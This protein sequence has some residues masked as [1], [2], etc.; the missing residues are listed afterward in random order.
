MTGERR[1]MQ[2]SER[3]MATSGL[4]SEIGA[5]GVPMK[6]KCWRGLTAAL[7]A[8]AI[9]CFL[10]RAGAEIGISPRSVW[11]E[12]S[13]APAFVVARGEPLYVPKDGGPLLSCIYA[14]LSAI[15]YLPATLG[16]DPAS[17]IRIGTAISIVFF[18][19]PAA[20]ALLLRRWSWP[21]AA[22]YLSLGVGSAS[23]SY[24]IFPIHA[25]APAL[26]F[27][28]LGAICLAGREGMRWKL[29]GGAL[30]MMAAFSKQ[31]FLPVALVGPAIVW[32]RDGLRPA[33]ACLAGAAGAAIVLLLLSRWLLGSWEDLFFNLV[34]VPVGAGFSERSLAVAAR[35]L[36]VDMAPA[37]CVSGIC[38]LLLL[39]KRGLAGSTALTEAGM[40]MLLSLA[41]WPTSVAGFMKLGGYPNA[42]APGVYLAIF[43][44]CF[45]AH[46]AMGLGR[47]VPLGIAVF[48]VLAAA[49]AMPVVLAYHREWKG[50]PATWSQ[51]AFDYERRDPGQVYFPA[52]PL[53]SLMAS[54]RTYHMDDG[55]YCRA[56]AGYTVSKEQLMRYL[57]ERFSHVACIPGGRD[58]LSRSTDGAL[59]DR[60]E[61][62]RPAGLEGWDV[63]RFIRDASRGGD[64]GR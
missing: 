14:P 28:G 15:S 25:D 63:V 34:T 32:W 9:A 10:V 23:V 35:A 20:L 36:A 48:S 13:L 5:P 27:V 62:D 4:D 26:G 1:G 8:I 6:S 42:L 37:L 61:P 29:V 7:I 33:A 54:G 47:Q 43:A 56:V 22:L 18:M 51:R 17:A 38:L 46:T 60:L 50:V 55:L 49:L 39:R 41:L 24:S 12:R 19:L 45:A 58:L 64:H 59:D 21:S 2:S 3:R 31:N 40:M 11:N 52:N 53:A 44:A 57:P 16:D 30:L